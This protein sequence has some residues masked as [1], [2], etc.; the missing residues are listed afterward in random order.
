MSPRPRSPRPSHDGRGGR[1]SKSPEREDE[2]EARHRFSGRR[3]SP[4]ADRGESAEEQSMSRNRRS[5]VSLMVDEEAEKWAALCSALV[6]AE[7]AKLRNNIRKRKQMGQSAKSLHA[8]G[9]GGRQGSLTGQ[10]IGRTLW[11]MVLGSAK[12]VETRS[13]SNV[14]VDGY[15]FA[16]HSMPLL[17]RAPRELHR[18]EPGEPGKGG[19]HAEAVAHALGGVRLGLRCRAGQ[20][21]LQHGL[22]I[23]PHR[24]PVLFPLLPQ[25]FANRNSVLTSGVYYQGQLGPNG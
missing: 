7:R 5:S 13:T 15:V 22:P 24:R 3:S 9:E 23:A 4:R 12:E 25:A 1:R 21:H 8:T 20:L 18:G 6:H 2:D 16:T 11:S 10:G 19:R 14:L 17:R